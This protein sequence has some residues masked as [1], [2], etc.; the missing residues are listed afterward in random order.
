VSKIAAGNLN[1]AAAECLRYN[2]DLA[3]IG[4]NNDAIAV[5]DSQFLLDIV[6]DVVNALRHRQ[7]LPSNR[8]NCPQS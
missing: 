8:H 2:G 4:I 7:I 5:V 1:L 3:T 6:K